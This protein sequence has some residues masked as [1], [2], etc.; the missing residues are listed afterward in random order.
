MACVCS[1]PE[2]ERYGNTD[3]AFCRRCGEILHGSIDDW[4]WSQTAIDEDDFR[5]LAAPATPEAR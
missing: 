3:S 1:P 2:P 5:W 4:N